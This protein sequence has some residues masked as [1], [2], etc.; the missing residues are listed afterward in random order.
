M[1]GCSIS[2]DT[3]CCG[4]CSVPVS[5]VGSAMKAG[6]STNS[7]EDPPL[8]GDEVVDEDLACSSSWTEGRSAKDVDPTLGHCTSMVVNS[9]A[10]CPKKW[11]CFGHKNQ[12][13]RSYSLHKTCSPS[14]I[15]LIISS[16]RRY[17]IPTEAK[18]AWLS[19]SDPLATNTT[20]S[21]EQPS[22]SATRARA[23][24]TASLQA[25]PKA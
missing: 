23:L 19:A 18:M 20:S 15:C 21:G 17:H 12:P 16:K 24:T 14:Y 4:R 13:Q 3:T 10:C 9:R 22:S 2:E 7:E 8:D 1:A 5:P 11:P 25:L 6:R